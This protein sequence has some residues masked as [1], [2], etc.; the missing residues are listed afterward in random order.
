M[1]MR[2]MQ[3][4]F[5]LVIILLFLFNG[6]IGQTAAPGL[7]AGVTFLE[8]QRSSY[9][10]VND[11]LS[12]RDDSLK[13]QFEEKGLKW[14]AR[15]IYIRSFKY[16]SQLEVWVKQ[17][18]QEKYKLFK[19]Y[20][21]CALAGT[22]GPKRMQGDYQVPEGIY[23]INE[24]NPK[25]QYHLSLGLN[26]PNAS[27]RILSDSLQPGG[28]IYIHGSCVTTGCIPVTD[29]QIEDIYLLAMH[30]RDEGQDFIPV[31]IFPVQF[32]IKASNDYL[33]KYLKDFPEYAAMTNSLR[34]VYGYFEKTKEIP[35]ILI[36]KKGEYVV[37]GV[38]N[39][40]ENVKAVKPLRLRPPKASYPEDDLARVVNKLPVYPGGPE[41]FVEFINTA[42]RDLSQYLEED[43]H[44]AYILIEYIIDS[45]GKPVWAKVVKGGN[46]E[47]NEKLEERFEKMPTWQPAIRQEKN[48]GIKLKQTIVVEKE[49]STQ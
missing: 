41:A 35:V 40:P 13:Q 19:T 2:W 7:T 12:R 42:S 31:H 4:N 6:L 46:E 18:V 15:F 44:K 38:F 8:L 34:Q 22:L 28:D 29:K 39:E 11:I 21:V 9:P 33:N 10:K 27:D 26:Y 24:F 30:A 3:R 43:Q 16:D 14:P 32:K 37:N 17:T 23:Y 36:N 47:L 49:S 45:S 20:K 1:N 25:S 48:V 5:P